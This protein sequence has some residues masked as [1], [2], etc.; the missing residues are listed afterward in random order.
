MLGLWTFS[1]F[2][3]GDGIGINTFKLILKRLITEDKTSG[4]RKAERGSLSIHKSVVRSLTIYQKGNGE[5]TLVLLHGYGAN[6]RDLLQMAS[7]MPASLRLLFPEGPYDLDQ[8][9]SDAKAWFMIDLDTL[10]FD[11]EQYALS[12]EKLLAAF[13]EMGLDPAKTVIGGFSQGAM[14]AL[15]AHLSSPVPF[16]GLALFSTTPVHLETLTERAL[17]HKTH[18][19]QSHGTYDDLLPIDA[20]QNLFN[21]LTQAGWQGQFSAFAGGHEMPLETILECEDFVNALIHQ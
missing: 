16:L 1:P 5:F 9:Y 19:F 18:F 7:V 20:A 13:A 3:E 15:E 4:Q 17:S 2:F 14:M 12:T 11:T 10:S 6:G 8:F 21:T